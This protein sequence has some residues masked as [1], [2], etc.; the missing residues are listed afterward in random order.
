MVCQYIILEPHQSW[1]SLSYL[2]TTLT[3]SRSY[4]LAA[5]ACGVLALL[6]I[7][8]LLYPYAGISHDAR[9]YTLQALNH[10]H[11]ELYMQDV[12]LRFGSQDSY[13][14]FTPIYS[15]LAA[16][17]G[18]EHAAALL[19]AASQLG[20]LSLCFMIA[21]RL[22]TK[23][24]VT[25]LL[26]VM[27]LPSNYGS[28]FIFT[29][30]ETFITP[31][32]LAQCFTLAGVLFWLL[33]KRWL[34][35]A[36]FCVALVIHPIMAMAGIAFVMT[37]NAIDHPKQSVALALAGLLTVLIAALGPWG[38][39]FRF[40]ADWLA[41]VNARSPYLFLKN[42]LYADWARLA[43][44]L[45]TLG[46]CT[47][48]GLSDL[49][50]K[51]AKTA[52]FM[53][54]GGLLVTYIGNDL[55]KL[56]I[57]TQG[58]AWRWLWLSTLLA[59][60]LV[61]SLLQKL[62]LNNQAGR[63]ASLLLIA[64]WLVRNEASSLGIIVFAIAASI[65][66]I[67]K[68]GTANHWRLMQRAAIGLL[69]LAIGWMILM[70]QLTAGYLIYTYHWPNWIDLLRDTCTDGLIPLMC[71]AMLYI[72][73]QRGWRIAQAIATG[74]LL[75]ACLVLGRYAWQNWSYEEYPPQVVA[76]LQA[77]R[78][79]IPANEEVLWIDGPTPAW[80]ALQRPSYISSIQSTAA[81]FSRTA[82]IVLGERAQHVAPIFPDARPLEWTGK[83]GNIEP[84]TQSLAVI[85]KHIPVHFVVTTKQLDV[86][87]IATAPNSLPTSYNNEK[88]YRCSSP[89]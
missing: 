67:N 68:F 7:W 72:I 62:W 4:S 79:L 37:W 45:A 60:L 38:E 50:R 36:S 25:A 86:Q 5:K 13:T 52:L 71:C 51:I 84:E 24:A 41:I 55:L 65:V 26:L 39:S 87:P 89:I 33:G 63:A 44:P 21:R 81:L 57:T 18:I 3:P 88:L 12:F 23:F 9:L 30:F 17:L 74:C 34:T 11:P 43:V 76:D 35:L 61:P 54:C 6:L 40:D 82:A 42:W 10:I 56:V 14:L 20:F 19:T 80:L 85:C 46:L 64:A 77:W 49:Q 58:Q 59:V 70:N 15:W 83:S 75:L 2:D 66:S 29:Y 53:A 32:L 1:T 22:S 27:V 16:R 28:D 48:C 73:H 78:D 31:R 69:L 47:V 8:L